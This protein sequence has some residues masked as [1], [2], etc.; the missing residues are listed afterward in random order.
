M[1][2]GLGN[3]LAMSASTLN[4]ILSSALQPGLSDWCVTPTSIGTLQHPVLEWPVTAKL[5][6]RNMYIYARRLGDDNA[7]GSLAAHSAAHFAALS[8]D[9]LVFSAAPL[10]GYAFIALIFCRRTA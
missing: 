10:T 8:S 3:V 7:H 9:Y 4:Y 1:T 5:A 2:D 6:A